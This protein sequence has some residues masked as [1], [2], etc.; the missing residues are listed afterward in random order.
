MTAPQYALHRIY[1]PLISSPFPEC[2]PSN[3]L[4][5]FS[6]EKLL[7]LFE[8]LI[9]ERLFVWPAVYLKGF[10]ET[11]AQ[12]YEY[13]KITKSIIHFSSEM[14]P[15]FFSSLQL[16]FVMEIYVGRPGEKTLYLRYNTAIVLESF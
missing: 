16:L 4:G 1:F 15:P 12:C 3:S 9:K 6:R 14:P 2:L 5:A 10:S 13:E 8:D 11:F 7:L